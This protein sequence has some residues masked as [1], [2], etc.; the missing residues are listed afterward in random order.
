M[1][2]VRLEPAAPGP[3]VKHSTTE[4]LRSLTCMFGGLKKNMYHGRERITVPYPFSNLKKL[5]ANEEGPWGTWNIV[6][7]CHSFY[8]ACAIPSV[9]HLFNEGLD[10]GGGVWY[11]LFIKKFSLLFISLKFWV[12]H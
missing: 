12:I 6:I 7:S 10:G 8:P 4:P 3:R 9:C 5:S 1:T 2:P 11:S